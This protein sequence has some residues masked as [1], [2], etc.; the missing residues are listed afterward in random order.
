MKLLPKISPRNDDQRQTELV[1]QLKRKEAKIGGQLFGPIPKGHRRE[2]FCLDARTWV[3][4]EEWLQDG[5]RQ[6]VTTHYN[7]RPE[8]ILKQQGGHYRRLT[9]QEAYNLYR[10]VTLYRQ[11]THAEYQRMLAA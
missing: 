9:E 4:H 3:W 10:A 6:S 2:F 1:Q 7:V 5:Q 11:R 8:G